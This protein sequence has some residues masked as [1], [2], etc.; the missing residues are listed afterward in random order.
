MAEL[1]EEPTYRVDNFL[2]KVALAFG[3]FI[4]NSE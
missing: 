1:M 4:W 3:S 2:M